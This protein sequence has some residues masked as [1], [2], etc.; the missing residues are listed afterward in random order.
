MLGRWTCLL[1]K[2]IE[3]LKTHY[4]NW[5]EEVLHSERSTKDEKWSSSITI[6]SEDFILSVKDESSLGTRRKVSE[7]G[8]IPHYISD[9]QG[10]ILGF[11]F[12]SRWSIFG[13]KL[14]SLRPFC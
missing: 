13:R 1:D 5:L 14:K 8:S 12:L 3:E 6:G 2:K 9:T 4:P 10:R 11:I 7:N